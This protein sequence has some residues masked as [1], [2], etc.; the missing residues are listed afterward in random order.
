[1]PAFEALKYYRA[2]DTIE[3]REVVLDMQVMDYQRNMDKKER[4]KFHH[5]IFDQAY[6]KQSKKT[7]SPEDFVRMFQ[8]VVSGKK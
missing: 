6:P 7:A 2:I 3:A 5:A 4:S 1:M 8:G